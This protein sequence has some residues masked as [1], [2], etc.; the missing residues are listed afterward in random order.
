MSEQRAPWFLEEME[1]CLHA[2]DEAWA[3]FARDMRFASRRGTSID[4]VLERWR[5]VIE[6]AVLGEADPREFAVLT[7]DEQRQ[8]FARLQRKWAR[9]AAQ[10]WP[11]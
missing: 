4:E 7:F 2:A 10:G 1:D 5:P 11:R 8:A 6:A 9:E 3:S